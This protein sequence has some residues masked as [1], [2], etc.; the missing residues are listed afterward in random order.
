VETAASTL[1]TTAATGG[2]PGQAVETALVTKT[3]PHRTPEV[4]TG[5]NGRGSAAGPNNG[6]LE[7]GLGALLMLTAAAGAVGMRRRKEAA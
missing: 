2:T 3:P 4:P 7:L 6:D 1:T 5:S